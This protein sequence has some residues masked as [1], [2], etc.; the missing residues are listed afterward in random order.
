MAFE[1]STT[2]VE[3]LLLGG[4]F[5]GSG[6][7]GTLTSARSLASH[8]KRGDYYPSDRVQVVSVDEVD[9]GDT[10]MVAYLGSPAAI[11][12]A[13]Y[14]EGPV[15]AVRQV[16]QRLAASG[17]RL[18]YVVPPESG[19]LGFLVACLVAA[20]LEL[21]VIDADGAGR[22]V[23]SLPQLT[24][25]AAGVNPRPTFLVSQSGL[26]VELD[27]KPRDEANG[28]SAHQQDVAAI[29]DQ[30]L[31]P[32][33]AESDFGQF[34]G[35]AIWI[36]D[37]SR[38]R[39][40][41]PIRGT[42]TRALTLG[43]AL[44]ER[45]IENADQLL[46]FLSARFKLSAQRIFGP[47]KF[48]SAELDTSSGFDLGKV[49]L[50]AGDKICTVLYQNESLLTWVSDQPQ[51]VCMA[52]DSIAYFVEGPG[53]SVFSNGDLVLADGSLNPALLSRSVTLVGILA[54]PE[55]QHSLILDSF[56]LLLSSMGYLGPYVPL[57]APNHI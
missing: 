51:P 43:R 23:P 49:R 5:F 18:A 45:S 14:P 36:M 20:K 27:V 56:M 12:G 1:L 40:A 54:D 30:M 52:P 42:L 28:S 16:Q 34:G 11:N 47:A 6:G 46:Q 57:A 26:C 33:V 15:E 38:L 32:I 9:S 22:A 48:I 17:R 21:K 25:A 50:Q 4:C 2:D 44:Q 24:Y 3:S 8:F 29:I 10:V 19:A 39:S 13:T 55:L 31:R 35:L 37:P 7:G 53:R 41:L